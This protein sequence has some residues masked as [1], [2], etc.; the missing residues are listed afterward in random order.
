VFAVYREY[1]IF[2][3][4]PDGNVEWRGVVVGLDAARAR[5]D[6][7]AKHSKNEFFAL[8]TPTNE[9]VERVNTRK[10]PSRN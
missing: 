4:L 6:S 2:E 5:L 1:D 10:D 8:H 9:I 7:L 3:Q